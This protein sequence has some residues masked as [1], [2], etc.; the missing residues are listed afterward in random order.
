MIF[1]FYSYKGGVGRSMALA[2]V[3]EF[4]YLAGLKVLIVDWDLEAPGLERYFS[5][6]VEEVLDNP[7]VIEML[8]TYKDEMSLF[9][10]ESNKEF[11]YPDIHD[12]TIQLHKDDIGETGE[13]WLLPAGQ[14]DNEEQFS[15]YSKQITNFNW[16][17]FYDRWEGARYFEQLQKQF[18]DFDVVLIDS[19]TGVT[20]IG[21]VCT[22]Q[23]ADVVVMLCA[24]NNQNLEGSLEMA[25]RF[26]S[27]TVTKLRQGRELK[28]LVIPARVEQSSEIIRLNEF[29]QRFI[30]NFSKFIPQE[31]QLNDRQFFQEHEIP[32]VGLYAFEEMIVFNQAEKRVPQLERAYLILI[33]ELKNFAPE[34]HPLSKLPDNLISSLPLLPT[35]ILKEAATARQQ[36]GMR[37]QELAELRRKLAKAKR[38]HTRTQFTER[39]ELDTH[40]ANLTQAKAGTDEEL[41]TAEHTLALTRLAMNQKV[42]SAEQMLAEQQDEVSDKLAEIERELFQAKT[43]LTATKSELQAEQKRLVSMQATLE[44]TQTELSTS[45]SETAS[46]TSQLGELKGQHDMTVTDLEQKLTVA[47]IALNKT[48]D[49]LGE[50]NNLIREYGKIFKVYWFIISIAVITELAL[51]YYLY[52]L[53]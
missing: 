13:L 19:R 2:N 9:G 26:S 24:S 3:A 14:R 23:L 52:Y 18:N 12:Y 50:R 16:K 7:G 30:D 5:D 29:R 33:Q 37:E 1:T 25:K 10:P 42:S 15:E 44:Q 39:R 6:D 45:Q 27:P 41:A 47:K 36:L 49:E 11:L 53:K 43:T 22:Y 51:L 35:D 20:E 46:V 4:M 17:R 32:Y 34:K 38:D 21:G 8:L 31:S 40:E 48:Q 28:T